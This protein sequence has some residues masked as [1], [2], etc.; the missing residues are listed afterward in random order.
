MKW[1]VYGANGY[2]G[3]LIAEEAARRGLRPIL[4]GRN[5]SAIE[6][7]A[8]Q[9]KLPVRAF[10]LDN[11][12]A[13][14]AGLKDIGLVLHCAGPFSATSAPMVEACLDVGAHYLDITGEIDIF[15]ACHARDAVAR[16]RGVVLIPGTGFDVVPTDC[17][18]AQLKREMP[19]ATSLVLA[20]DAT[21]GP[22]PGTA[23]TGVEG[24]GKGGR[25][26]ID[27][28]MTRVPL[29]WKT[30]SF[31]R[32]GE[33][34]F[35]MTIPWGD[36][37]T[38]FVSTGIPNIEVYMGVPPASATRLRRIRW[39]GPL[40][41]TAP[42]QAWLKSQVAKRV[43]GPT[44]KGRAASD[45]RVWGEVRDASGNELKA[46]LSTPNGYELTVT[47]S[48]GIVQRLLEGARPAGGYYT[49]SQ[50]MGADYV[51]ELQGVKRL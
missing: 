50:L 8:K 6:P 11:P 43:R 18:A 24:L 31:D 10:A 33:S 12:A 40:L 49:P 46:Q 21:G 3:R 4:A 36:V 9:L 25:A 15:A 23:L 13:V 27:G 14:R 51:L 37:Y 48:L 44:E 47:A 16:K 41:G 45:T 7:L 30:R 42:V 38:A 26:R 28:K 35:A 19:S 17:L 1:M 5:A 22:S 32:D 20:F 2:T 39:L 34:R 29:A